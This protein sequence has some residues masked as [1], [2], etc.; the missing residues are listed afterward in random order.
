M[1]PADK[2][3]IAPRRAARIDVLGYVQRLIERHDHRHERR[4]QA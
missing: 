4:G 3:V 2:A 1:Q